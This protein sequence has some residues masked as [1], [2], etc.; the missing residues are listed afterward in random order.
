MRKFI[1]N[2]FLNS[3]SSENSIGF[4]KVTNLTVLIVSLGLLFA[5]CDEDPAGPDEDPGDDP[6]PV[7]VEAAFTMEPEE[8]LVGDEVTLDAGET[9]VT[10]SSD[11]S[12]SWALTPPSDSNAELESETSVTTGFTADVEGEYS[13]ELT[14]EANGETDNT[15]G[16][17][18]ALAVEEIASNITS[19]RTLTPDVS[20]IVT[21]EIS[22]QA[23]LTI[24]PGTVIEF[25][26]DARL[27]IDDG[28]L[29]ADGTEADSIRFT[30][31]EQ[32][33]GWWNGI[34]VSESADLNNQMNYVIVE[35]AGGLE[36][37]N[38]GSANV[39]V[40][41]DRRDAQMAIT[42]S[43]MRYSSNDGLYVHSNGPIPNSGN[44]TFTGNE[45]AAVNIHNT[46][47]HHLDGASSYTGNENDY[48]YVR[49]GST[50]SSEDVTWE[51]LEVPYRVNSG[52]VDISDVNLTIEAGAE[53]E[54]EQDGR[55]E[56]DSGGGLMANGT[57]AEPILFTAVQETPGWWEGIYVSD[58][59]NINNLLDYVIV[60]YAGGLSSSNTGSGNVT[61]GRDRRDARMAI[62][63]SIMRH[64]S[65]A[66]LYVH[67]NGP[68]EGTGNNT[69]TNNDGAAVNIHNT[70]AHYLD[71]NSDFSGNENDYVYVRGGSSISSD[72]VTWEALNVPYRLNE[73]TVEVSD[74]DLT[75]EAG[76]VVEFEQDGRLEIDSGGGLMAEGDED[77]RI[78]F[79]ATQETPGWWEGIYISES[80]NINNILDYVTVEYGGGIDS[81]NTES[82]NIMIARDRRDAQ[83]T[84][85]NSEIFN[86]A[87]YGIFV[88]SNGVANSDICS[89]N[90]F[91]GNANADCRVDD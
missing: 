6:D 63:N 33:P 42:N 9:T 69:Y 30:G 27:E 15:S 58:S 65:N 62:T 24:E 10:N 50:I 70:N 47:T 39:M 36:S 60:E 31:T 16:S 83:M 67:S 13:V 78:L 28:A 20:Y 54:F 64:S 34:Y 22:V 77:N 84:V 72:D 56:V 14:V 25:E 89:E 2:K 61:V 79:T 29:I 57:E 19:D 18:E 40:G 4:R 1:V 32:S 75:I 80:E 49:T 55:L 37:S 8:P 48:V 90:E 59:S 71:G 12:Y 35:Y 45:G 82:A 26:Q 41:R 76:A 74:V 68:I 7:E 21:N 43:T 86:S 85:T 23:D 38:T 46:H 88:H 87:G 52:S 53:L 11:I 51:A 5:A 66:G 44:N 73:R 17:V 81:S 91:D 3:K